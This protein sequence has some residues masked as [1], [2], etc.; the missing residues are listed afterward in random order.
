MKT[1]RNITILS[2]ILILIAGL[3]SCAEPNLK[4]EQTDYIIDELGNR[5][6]IIEV[7]SCEYIY[8]RGDSRMGIAHKGNCKFCKEREETK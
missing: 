6:T 1:I 3:S 5:F 7:D 2:F 8:Y 4:E